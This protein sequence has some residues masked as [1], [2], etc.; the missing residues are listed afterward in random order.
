MLNLTIYFDRRL[1]GPT[2]PISFATWMKRFINME[3]NDGGRRREERGLIERLRRYQL[4]RPNCGSGVSVRAMTVKLGRSGGMPGR[5]EP[6]GTVRGAV[7]FAALSGAGVQGG[8][9]RAG[10][11]RLRE[12]CGLWRMIKLDNFHQ[13]SMHSS[14]PLFRQLPRL[15]ANNGAARRFDHRWQIL[16]PA[17]VGAGQGVADSMGLP[18]ERAVKLC[19]DLRHVQRPAKSPSEEW[20]TRPNLGFRNHTGEGSVF[21]AK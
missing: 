19:I 2:T 20:D 16:R 6:R 7:C 1:S 18:R 9:T 4:S 12:G 3:L 8:E 11:A 5:V 10:V 21:P 14:R 15:E 13:R 17:R